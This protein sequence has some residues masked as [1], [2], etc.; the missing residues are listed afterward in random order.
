MDRVF[1]GSF[2]FL[3]TTAVGLTIV[4]PKGVIF[5]SMMTYRVQFLLLVLAGWVE[6]IL[7]LVEIGE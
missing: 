7:N 5:R 1:E 2:V 6:D 4:W 3:D